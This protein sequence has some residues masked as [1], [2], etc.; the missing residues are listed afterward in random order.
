MP[1]FPERNMYQIVEPVIQWLPSERQEAVL[2]A[3]P[4]DHQPIFWWLKYHLRRPGE[5]CALFKEDFD[6]SIFTVRRGFSAKIA[7]NRTKTGETHTVPA[8]SSFLPFVDIEREKQKRYQILSPHFFVHPQGR[9]TGKHYT[10]VALEKIWDRAAA[11]VGETISLY[12][13][14]K[15]ST[16]SQ[17]KNEWGYTDEQIREG[18][19]WA[20]LDS[21]RKYAKTEVSARRNLLEGP[22]VVLGSFRKHDETTKR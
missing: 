16:A 10:L 18:G 12:A 20:R 2:R 7:V 13:G 8:V 9:K 17:M 19:D 3:I 14:L 6:G 22:K 4:L 21:V 11:S 5:A 1:E 15:H